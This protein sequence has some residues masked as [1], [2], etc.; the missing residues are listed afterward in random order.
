MSKEMQPK[1]V[2]VYSCDTDCTPDDRKKKVKRGSEI[3][4]LADGTDVNLD[5]AASPF[6][7]PVTSVPIAANTFVKLKFGSTD[8]EYKYHLTCGRCATPR[9][10]EDPS[11]IVDL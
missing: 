9:N 1:N 7:P 10:L 6:D 4:L 3:Y 8:G 11:M 5:F 2:I